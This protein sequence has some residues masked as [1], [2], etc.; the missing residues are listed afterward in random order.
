M[1]GAMWASSRPWRRGRSERRVLGA[2]ALNQLGQRLAGD[3]RL[4]V[5]RLL[6]RREGVF[7]LEYLVEEEFGRFRLRLVDHEGP[8]ARLLLRLRHE[9]LQDRGHRLGF[10]RLGFPERRHHQAV[11]QSRIVE[12]GSNS[13]ARAIDE[14]RLASLARIDAK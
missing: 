14:I 2:L 1:A 6:M 10:V 13:F 9:A 7:V 8:N 5:R 4:E 12:H 11:S 3:E